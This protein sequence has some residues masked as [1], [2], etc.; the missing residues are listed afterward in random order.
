MTH[1]IHGYLDHDWAS[2]NVIWWYI[3]IYVI[4][5]VPC[6]KVYCG[7]TQSPVPRFSTHRIAVQVGKSAYKNGQFGDTILWS[8]YQLYWT[9]CLGKCWYHQKNSP[10]H[11]YLS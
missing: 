7:S 9:A 2:R 3:Y 5:D 6:G 4:Q 1:K 8:R 10:L 11:C